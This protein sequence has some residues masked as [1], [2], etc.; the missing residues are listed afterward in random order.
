VS[1][2][3]QVFPIGVV[4]RQ[5]EAVTIEVYSKYKNALL[6]LDQHSHIIVFSWFHESDS[7]QK[8]KILRVHPKGNK[9]NIFTCMILSIEGR[10]IH[11]DK[12]D[13]LDGTPVID[14]K[15]YIPRLD[16]AAEVRAP[17][18]MGKE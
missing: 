9:A 13:A 10:V 4:K 16:S 11:I 14:I 1:E 8:R 2:S 18:W 3:F 12:I 5:N 17:S 7:P 15:P 6:G